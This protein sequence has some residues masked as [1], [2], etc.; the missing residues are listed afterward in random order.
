MRLSFKTY[1]FTVAASAALVAAGLVHGFWTDRW[2][3]AVETQA[4]AERLPTLPLEIGDWKG[5]DL[6]VKAGQA[7]PGVAGCLQRSYFNPH[8]GVSVVI[9]LVCGRPGPVATHTPEVC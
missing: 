4:A 3:P 9:A 7:G 5:K 6:D 1:L 8:R 2:A